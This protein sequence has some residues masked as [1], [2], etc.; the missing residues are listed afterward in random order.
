MHGHM[1][2]CARRAAEL[3]QRCCLGWRRTKGQSVCVGVTVALAVELTMPS[4]GCL[5]RFLGLH[6]EAES[7]ARV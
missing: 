5:Q 2:M 4:L 6:S 1:L 7:S 3:D